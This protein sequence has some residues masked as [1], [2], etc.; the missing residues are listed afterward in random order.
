[1]YLHQLQLLDVVGND[2]NNNSKMFVQ[3]SVSRSGSIREWDN[4][5]CSA[6]FRSVSLRAGLDL[7][8]EEQ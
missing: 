4:T 1:M 6:C 2:T 3:L 8:S 5:T 7:I